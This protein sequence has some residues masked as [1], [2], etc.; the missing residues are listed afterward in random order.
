MVRPGVPNVFISLAK[1]QTANGHFI[2]A[3][4][5]IFV[6]EHYSFLVIFLIKA[7]ALKAIVE[8]G[9]ELQNLTEVTNELKELRGR[10]AL[11]MTYR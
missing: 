1:R 5:P 10:T 4:L 11:N 8:L 3:L 9:N 7:E 2:W 6:I